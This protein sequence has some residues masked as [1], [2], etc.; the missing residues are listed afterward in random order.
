VLILPPGHYQEVH[1]PRE[2]SRRE[3]AVLG[4]GA[5]FTVLIVAVTLF[6]LTSHRPVNGHGCLSF[7]Y[8]MAMGGEEFHE[9]GARAK[10]TCASPP[11]LGGLAHDFAVRL[12]DA[13]RGA[14][15]SYATTT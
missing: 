6:S 2:R 9:C 13:C 4:V 15:M 8:A 11:H 14:G 7:T 12:R 10:H 5:L 3:R 1:K